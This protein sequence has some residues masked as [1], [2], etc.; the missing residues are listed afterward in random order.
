MSKKRT[1]SAEFKRAVK[2]IPGLIVE[3]QKRAEHTEKSIPPQK[4]AANPPPPPPIGFYQSPAHSRRWMVVGVVTC[5]LIIVTFWGVYIS[6]IFQKN[7]GNL[8]PN[9][10]L[11]KSQKTDF[12][13]V[14]GTLTE[15]E[16]ALKQNVKNP[17]ELKAM[18][19]DALLPLFTASSTTDTASTTT[20]LTTA[21][22]TEATSTPSTTTDN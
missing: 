19:A 3:Q 8:I 12:S 16:D 18:V 5:S 9:S 17:T 13:M 1:T 20:P 4:Q 22:T 11:L 2:Q 15:M 21:T 14:L 7:Q 10:S 6:S